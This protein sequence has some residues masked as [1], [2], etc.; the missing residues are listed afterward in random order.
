MKRLIMRDAWC[1]E[2][3]HEA[4]AIT[5]SAASCGLTLCHRLKAHV[6][7]NVDTSGNCGP[8]L[9]V[10]SATCGNAAVQTQSFQQGL[11]TQQWLL[12]PAN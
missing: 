6:L 8:Y 2:H 9:G 3:E 4:M 11:D 12:I 7:Q 10:S 5:R 1:H